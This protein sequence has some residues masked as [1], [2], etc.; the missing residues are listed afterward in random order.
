MPERLPALV[1]CGFPL[2]VLH[3]IVSGGCGCRTEGNDLLTPEQAPHLPHVVVVALDRRGRA[4]VPAITVR[5]GVSKPGAELGVFPSQTSN[6]EAYV[7]L[8]V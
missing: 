6:L 4:S 7:A 5:L 8:N 2:G 3:G 1:R